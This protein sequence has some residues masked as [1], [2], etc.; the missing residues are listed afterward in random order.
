[1][2]KPSKLLL[3]SRR[4]KDKYWHLRPHSL[5]SQGRYIPSAARIGAPSSLHQPLSVF[6]N[7]VPTAQENQL[8]FTMHLVIVALWGQILDR[9]AT[10]T[11]HVATKC[12]E[13]GAADENK[14]DV[15]YT[16]V[17]EG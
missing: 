10:D 17:L 9:A 3:F 15:V 16:A 2:T 4:N 13:L 5:C 8:T 6:L 11:G 1:M 7:A 14:G 12:L